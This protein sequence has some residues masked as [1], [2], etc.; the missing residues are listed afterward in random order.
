[1]SEERVEPGS[2]GLSAKVESAERRLREAAD[3]ASAAEQRATAEI[4]ALEADLEQERLRAAERIEELR[5]GH[6]EELSRERA[7][8]ESAIAAAEGRLAEIETQIEAAE[9]RVEAAERRAT[10]AE[11]AIADAGA[12]ARE[13]AAAWLRGQVEAIRREAGRR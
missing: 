8:K 3:S 11:G 10:E 7:A 2:E 5:R 1:M 12:R 9:Q 13:A 4:R 6:D